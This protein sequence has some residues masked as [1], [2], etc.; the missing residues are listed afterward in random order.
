MSQSPYMTCTELQYID[1]ALFF[2]EKPAGYCLK[3]NKK[4]EK[5]KMLK[6][7]APASVS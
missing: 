7:L 1:Q 3:R 5:T 2:L 6:G 4:Q